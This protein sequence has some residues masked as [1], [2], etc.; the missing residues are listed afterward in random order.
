M[1]LRFNIIKSTLHLTHTRHYYTL[2]P[3]ILN[4][5]P[6]S[7]PPNDHR[8]QENR[9]TRRRRH[10]PRLPALRPRGVQGPAQPHFCHAGDRRGGPRAVLRE[11]GRKQRHLHF[12]RE[13]LRRGQDR[14]AV[15]TEG[16]ESDA[17]CDG[18]SVKVW[19]VDINKEYC[20]HL[21]QRKIV[22]KFFRY[23]FIYVNHFHMI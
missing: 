22:P 14:E 3:L 8:P 6:I 23:N 9:D 4:R 17:V 20:V 16:G 5:I 7:S 15:P 2:N 18:D 1:L 13:R 11:F 19:R 10:N 21:K 12:V